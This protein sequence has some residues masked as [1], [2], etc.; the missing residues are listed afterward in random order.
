LQSIA[1]TR[2]SV[3]IAGDACIDGSL[4]VALPVGTRVT[5]SLRPERVQVCAHGH[6]I[7]S[8]AGCRLTGTLREVIYLADH[9]RACVA[10]RGN[11]DFTIKRPID[12]AHELP[13]IGEP[14]E[15][16]W[17]PEHCRA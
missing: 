14:V 5:V 1:G 3:R 8:T 2:C 11:D 10:L 9:V 6:T 15:L 13:A 4:A 12:E 17:A 7:G 16:A